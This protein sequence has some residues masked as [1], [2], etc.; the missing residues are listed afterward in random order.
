MLNT[1]KKCWDNG[2]LSL[3]STGDAFSQL[4]NNADNSSVGLAT[5]Q[6]EMFEAGTEGK[7]LLSVQA[8]PWFKQDDL[9]TPDA[10]H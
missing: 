6:G 5:V 3:L 4:V 8:A 7:Y 2:L 10:G 9:T 1:L